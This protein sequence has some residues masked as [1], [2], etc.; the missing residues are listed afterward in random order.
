M[1]F[2]LVLLYVL[3]MLVSYTAFSLRGTINLST[4]VV[5]TLVTIIFSP[6]T[7]ILQSGSSLSLMITLS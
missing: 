2:G 7:N 1:S 6:P 5:S 3:A 4:V